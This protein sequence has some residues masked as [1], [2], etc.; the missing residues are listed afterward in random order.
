[1]AARVVLCQSLRL[2]VVDFFSLNR[3]AS[4]PFSLL[5]VV[6]TEELVIHGF[7]R[8]GEG[9]WGRGEERGLLV[10]CSWSGFRPG[11]SGLV[12]I[13]L[14]RWWEVSNIVALFSK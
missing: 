9:G 5:S 1:M 8:R 2:F 12:R 13:L 14:L 6:N 11:T 10:F 4:S 7:E 3:K